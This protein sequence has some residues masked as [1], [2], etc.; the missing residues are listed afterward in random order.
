MK[1]GSENMTND[2]VVII[3]LHDSY[4]DGICVGVVALLI[5]EMQKAGFFFIDQVIWQKSNNKP[6]GNKT[7]RFV[8]GYE[9]ILI[10]SKSKD[11]Y[12]DQLKIYDPTKSATVKKGCSEQG[13]QRCRPK[14]LLSYF[15]SIPYH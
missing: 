12:Y 14:T 4:Q 9:S 8:N 15:K 5:T 2:G 3:N 10:F 6:Q 13:E 7:K 1:I 11:Y